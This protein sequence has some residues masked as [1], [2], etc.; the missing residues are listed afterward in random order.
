MRVSASLLL[1]SFCGVAYATDTGA[2]GVYLDVTSALGEVKAISGMAAARGES[3]GNGHD[4]DVAAWAVGDRSLVPSRIYGV[5]VGDDDVALVSELFLTRDGASVS[6][7]LEGIDED[8]A[9]GWWLAVEGGG[10]APTASSPNRLLHADET[11]VIDA[12]VRLPAAVDAQ[13]RQYGFE[14]VACNDDGSQLYVAFQGEWGDDPSGLIRIGRY[15]PATG[16][17]AFYHY[18]RSFGAGR[19]GL[20]EITWAGDDTLVILERDNLVTGSWNKRLTVVSVA[21]VEPAPAG[22]TP[23]ALEPTLLRDLLGVDGW[24]YEKAESVVIV[25]KGIL[26]V[27]DNDAIAG[28]PT[29]ALLLDKLERDLP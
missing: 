21:D 15:T 20:S 27:N 10:N 19:V 25:D 13:Q 7:D 2:P 24:P 23:P 29:E 8:P 14:G 22:S 4:D 6:Y 11:G 5:T 17:W 16:E 28:A 26:V 18:P 9:G 1:L 12:E 3:Q